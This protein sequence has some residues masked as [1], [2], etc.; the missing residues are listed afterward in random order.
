MLEVKNIHKSYQGA[1]LLLGIS[2]EV[3]EGE[4]VCILGPSGGGKSTLL[5]ITAGLEDAEQGKIYWNGE[6]LTSLPAHKR[7]FGLLFQDYALFPH[8]SVAENVG[9]GLKMK[10]LSQGEIKERVDELLKQVNL[11][12][13]SERRVTDL[14]GGEQQRV[15]LARTLAPYPQLLMLDEP[16]G[17]LDR[18]LS[19]QL[20]TDLRRILR[21]TS[22]PA[23]YVTHDQEE[24]F[25]IAD[26]ILLLHDGVIVQQGTPEH[27]YDHPASAWVARFLGLGS[28]ID[29]RMS[30]AGTIMSNLGIL[31][32]TNEYQH[33][34]GKNVA[35]LIRPEGA[36][37][38][39][40]ENSIQGIVADVLFQRS[41]YRVTLDS[42]VVA[43]LKE[44]PE[45]GQQVSVKFSIIE[46]LDDRR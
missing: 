3:I 33:S 29:G 37:M 8:L 32:P 19:D 9:F 21:D 28:V 22:V 6:D 35:V 46:C 41:Y 20:L 43:N 15:A 34:E 11:I 27:V 16:L 25:A 18:S 31:K 4:T 30:K 38:G 10:G 17:A 26:R 45:L 12:Q 24:A 23:I 42:G 39:E 40:G 2:F 44:A 5:R 7:N 13:F 1:P 14:S 36:V